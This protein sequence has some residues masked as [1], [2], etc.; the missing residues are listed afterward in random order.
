MADNSTTKKVITLKEMAEQALES[1]K[2]TSPLTN[3][4]DKE[5][6]SPLIQSYL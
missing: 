4:K 3:D 5:V 2:T 6:V 1:V